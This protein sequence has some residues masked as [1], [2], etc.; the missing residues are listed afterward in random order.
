MPWIVGA[1]ALAIALFA[2]FISV[3]GGWLCG[4]DDG[5]YAACQGFLDQQL[6][7][8]EASYPPLGQATVIRT[9]A[10][11]WQV[12]AYLT[13]ENARGFDMRHH[14]TCVATYDEPERWRGTATLLDPPH[15]PTSALPG[16][17]VATLTP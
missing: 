5:A 2:A 16:A 14:W 8:A 12:R 6:G 10:N 13:T 15:P 4:S 11:Q 7:A 9:G 1:A 17:R 3:N